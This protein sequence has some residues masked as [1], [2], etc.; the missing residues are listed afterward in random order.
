[1]Q[2][3]EIDPFGDNFFCAST[4]DFFEITHFVVF[5]RGAPQDW[6]VADFTYRAVNDDDYGT[7]FATLGFSM[8]VNR[9]MFIGI[10]HDDQAEILVKLGHLIYSL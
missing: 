8:D 7:R 10:E 1:M 2:H 5:L 9:I 4:D 3:K 6:G